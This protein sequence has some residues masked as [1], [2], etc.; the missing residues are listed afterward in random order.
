MQKIKFLFLFEIFL[1]HFQIIHRRISSH[2]NGL[3][4]SGKILFKVKLNNEIKKLMIHN[5]D[6]NY[7]DLILMLQRIFSDK[8]KQNDEFKIKYTDDENDLITISDDSDV[9]LALQTS[10]VLKLTIFLNEGKGDVETGSLRPSEIVDEL[11]NIRQSI[12]KFLTNFEKSLKLE[13]K[14]DDVTKST[15]EIKIV[16]QVNPEVQ[17]EFDP[18]NKKQESAHVLQKP[19]RAQTP[20]S[21]CSNEMTGR[22]SPRVH[23]QQQQQHQFQQTPQVQQQFQPQTQPPSFLQ[24]QNFQQ[25]LPQQPVQP[26]ATPIQ[27]QQHQPMQSHPGMGGPGQFM[28]NPALKTPSQ[29]PFPQQTPPQYPQQQFGMQQHQPQQQQQQ[30]QP[31]APMDPQHYYQQQ[32]Q[33]QYAQHPGLQQPG[34][35]QPQGLQNLQQQGLPQQPSSQPGMNPFSKNPNVS[36]ARPPSATI[37][38]QG[39]K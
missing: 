28:A 4:L 38:Q 31:N 32:Q 27:Q 21:I 8:I 11:K 39:Y 24:N 6:L 30:P 1:F 10:K 29:I 13:E 18:L 37:Y 19:S 12:D 9:S 20:D 5:D 35:H 33:N 3:D 25:H 7:N 17:K 2:M 15:D 26:Q 22:F 16:T 14:I 23:H 34:L 36:L